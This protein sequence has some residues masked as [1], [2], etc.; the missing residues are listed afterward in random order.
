MP[1]STAALAS[2]AAARAFFLSAFLLAALGSCAGLLDPG[3]RSLFLDWISP[4]IPLISNNFPFFSFDSARLIIFDTWASRKPPR[5]HLLSTFSS[6][7]SLISLLAQPQS[8]AV[9]P[10]SVSLIALSPKPTSPKTTSSSSTAT[11]S[12]ASWPSATSPRSL[13]KNT[14]WTM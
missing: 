1:L 5:P 9:L 12:S 7:I 4:F 14:G 13:G 8:L 11:K 2:F 10:L 6:L 3:R